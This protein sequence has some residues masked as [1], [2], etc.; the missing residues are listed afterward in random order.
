MNALHSAVR[1]GRVDI[2]RV[3]LK[4]GANAP[5]RDTLGRTPL[6]DV[7]KDA[8][9][10][11]SVVMARKVL[12]IEAGADPTL[13]VN[14]GTVDRRYAAASGYAGVVGVVSS[15][16]PEE[17]N[18]VANNGISPLWLVTRFGMEK[19][20]SHMSSL[21]ATHPARLN[22]STSWHSP[23]RTTISYG[24]ANVVRVFRPRDRSISTLTRHSRQPFSRDGTLGKL[25]CDR[26]ASALS[27]RHF[28]QYARN[29][30][31]SCGRRRWGVDP[32]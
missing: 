10:A 17:L 23:L 6:K 2:L 24:H 28:R 31:P 27:S 18:H 1:H 13:M 21:G 8:E 29:K 16:A 32:C 30:S 19:A 4:A 22:S 15:K 11:R 9:E 14:N 25:Q 3:L 20:V 26:R 7:C 5:A 12:E